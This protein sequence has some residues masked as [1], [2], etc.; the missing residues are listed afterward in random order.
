MNFTLGLA[1][2]IFIGSVNALFMT[3]KSDWFHSLVGMCVSGKM[4]SV[5]WL[6]IYLCLAVH[7]GEAV[8]KGSPKGLRA[9]LCLL[10][11]GSVA[12][13][14]V[15]FR[16]HSMAGGVALLAFCAALAAALFIIAAKETRHLALFS[17]P[18]WGWYLYLFFVNSLLASLN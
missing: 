1:A 14:F 8:G 18:V 2:V 15:F 16:L 3:P 7:I 12:W 10:I 17:A 6:V 11:L 9:V 4:H 5:C 13:C